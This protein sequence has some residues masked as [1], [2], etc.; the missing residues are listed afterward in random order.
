MEDIK[1]Y[2]ESCQI[3]QDHQY[4]STKEPQM[5]YE[6]REEVGVYFMHL[7]ENVY[8]QLIYYNSKF[9]DIRKPL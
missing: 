1:N 8:M 7:D 4:A 3:L 6:V 9:I 5:F 2:I